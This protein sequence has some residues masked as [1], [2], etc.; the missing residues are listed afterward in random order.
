MAD[1]VFAHLEL[2]VEA[3]TLNGRYVKFLKPIA[4]S[5]MELFFFLIVH[6]KCHLV[7]LYII[8]ARC[9]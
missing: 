9:N 8:M 3:I 5:Y 4:T 2:P 1:V 7:D 6:L